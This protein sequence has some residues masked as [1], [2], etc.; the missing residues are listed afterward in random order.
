[1]WWT[2]KRNQLGGSG[3]ISACH[4]VAI[5]A[6][7]KRFAGMAAADKDRV[8]KQKADQ[9]LVLKPAKPVNRDNSGELKLHI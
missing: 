1:M 9:C 6:E 5:P 7:Q 2:V 4:S 8:A 3:T